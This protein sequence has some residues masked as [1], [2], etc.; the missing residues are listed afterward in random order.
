M[1]IVNKAIGVESRRWYVAC[2]S[3]MKERIHIVDSNV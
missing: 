1:I 2:S 3:S